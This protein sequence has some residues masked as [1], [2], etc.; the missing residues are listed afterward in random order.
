VQGLYANLVEIRLELCIVMFQLVT[1]NS[2]R[3]I[4]VVQMQKFNIPPHFQR[5]RNAPVYS[6]IV[7]FNSPVDE[8]IDALERINY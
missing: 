1:N 6:S 3:F 8:A 2:D 5:A 4:F 7:I